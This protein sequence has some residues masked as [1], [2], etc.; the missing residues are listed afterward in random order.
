VLVPGI[1]DD[2]TWLRKTRDFILT[3]KNVK[4]IEVLPYH[5]M[6]AYKWEKLGIPYSLSGVKSPT[7][8][9]VENAKRILCGETDASEKAVSKT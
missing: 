8:E 5:S 9:R 7:A 4:K 3:L 1:T 2:D 6:G